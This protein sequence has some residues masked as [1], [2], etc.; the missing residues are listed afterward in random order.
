MVTNL[1]NSDA[2]E[3]SFKSVGMYSDLPLPGRAFYIRIQ[4]GL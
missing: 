3:P 2:R 1:F 4:H